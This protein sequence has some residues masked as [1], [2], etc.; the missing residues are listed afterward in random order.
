MNFE[1]GV[2][3]LVGLAV[4]SFVLYLV[5][6]NEPF[7]D[8]N[9]VVLMRLVLGLAMGILGATVPGFLNVSWKGG[10]L[11]VRA[12]GALALFVLTLVFTPTV[13]DNRGKGGVVQINRGNNNVNVNSGN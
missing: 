1:R 8:Q 9:L 4:V 7:V 5:A 11:A 10:G 6:R 3:T 2:A 13:L 12:G